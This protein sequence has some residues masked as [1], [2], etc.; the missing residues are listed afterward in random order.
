MFSHRKILNYNNGIDWNGPALVMD[1]EVE[2][3]TVQPIE[4][5]VSDEDWYE[6]S[7]TISPL[8]PSH[9]YGIDIFQATMTFV[10]T[11]IV[12]YT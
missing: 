7:Q 11:H 4:C 1:N 9:N 10:D 6:L 5:P 12:Q 2:S 8:A 3:I